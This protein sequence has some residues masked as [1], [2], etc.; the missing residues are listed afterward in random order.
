MRSGAG[1]QPDRAHRNASGWWNQLR[2]INAAED[3]HKAP[4]FVVHSDR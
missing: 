1:A 3:A 2:A 4:D